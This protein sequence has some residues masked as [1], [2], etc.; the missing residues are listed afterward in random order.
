MAAID[1]IMFTHTTSVIVRP[2]PIPTETRAVVEGNYR[3]LSPKEKERIR[4]RLKIKE[5]EERRNRRD[6]GSV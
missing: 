2:E 6:T 4:R 5:N 3:E 1:K